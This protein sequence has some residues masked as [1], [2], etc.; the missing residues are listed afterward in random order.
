MKRAG[1]MLLALALVQ[2]IQITASVAC[3][4]DSSGS[5]SYLGVACIG[6]YGSLG[7]FTDD[8]ADE[9]Y[10]RGYDLAQRGAYGE[11]IG[12]LNRAIAISPSP[13]AYV[14]RGNCHFSNKNYTRAIAD[15]T[16]AIRLNP[17][18]MVAYYDRGRCYALNGD[19]SKALT[20]F[21][22]AIR[23]NPK[24]AEAFIGRAEIY[25]DQQEYTKAI[26]DC[27]EAIRLDGANRNG[28]KSRGDAHYA[29]KE[30]DSAIADYS[31]VIRLDPN[32][33]IGFQ[34]RGL[35]HFA[36]ME[37]DKAI[38]DY[39][40]AVDLDPNNSELYSLRGYAYLAR[41]EFAK[42]IADYEKALKLNPDS[43]NTNDGL[44]W[45]L[46]TCPDATLRDGKKAMLYA[47]RASKLGGWRAATSNI[48]A[49]AYAENGQFDEAIKEQKSA[50]NDP[51]FERAYGV[52]ARNRLRLYE[53]RKPYR[54]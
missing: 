13:D 15:Y 49:A 5:T 42:A 38:A 52:S 26:T 32:N 12:E 54:E 47:K 45:V 31:E 48:L 19:R 27:T 51:E 10:K 24:R 21:A 53:Q 41:R 37:I 11:A 17:Q 8:K 18:D 46:A 39:K 25:H 36:K 9:Y 16:E 7:V 34:C 43:S 40:S 28:Y 35:A 4:E 30:F 22:E 3:A 33:A 2:G 50:L 20:D 23:L 44:A 29:L 14:C 6:P 1:I